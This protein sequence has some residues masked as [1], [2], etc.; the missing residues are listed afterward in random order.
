MV[1]NDPSNVCALNDVKAFKFEL[2]TPRGINA[3]TKG[4][5]VARTLR[6]SAA[7]HPLRNA[8]LMQAIFCARIILPSASGSALPCPDFSSFIFGAVLLILH[9]SFT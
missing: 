8:W 4:E 5:A 2:L 9:F 3:A 6:F 1:K 7:D